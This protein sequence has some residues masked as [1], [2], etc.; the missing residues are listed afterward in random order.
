MHLYITAL[1]YH[2]WM[3]TK[4]VAMEINGVHVHVYTLYM[5]ATVKMYRDLRLSGLI[6]EHTVHSLVYELRI[7]YCTLFT[8]KGGSSW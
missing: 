8:H 4:Q 3:V 1:H 7:N 5:Y 6:T 2:P